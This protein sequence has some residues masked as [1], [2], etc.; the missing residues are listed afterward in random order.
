MFDPPFGV[1]SNGHNISD[2]RLLTP[3]GVVTKVTKVIVKIKANYQY[4]SV[5]YRTSSLLKYNLKVT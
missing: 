2:T 3:L 4:A 5:R 1:I